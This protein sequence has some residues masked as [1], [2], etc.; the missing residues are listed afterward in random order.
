LKY[1]AYESL[2]LDRP[3]ERVLR[4]GHAQILLEEEIK[5]LLGDMECHLVNNISTLAAASAPFP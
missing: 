2:V 1:L 4:G 3:A 5:G